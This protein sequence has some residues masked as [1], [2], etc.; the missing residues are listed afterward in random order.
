MCSKLAMLLG[1]G[2]SS[3]T[4]TN[5]PVRIPTAAAPK[6]M[7]PKRKLHIALH[8]ATDQTLYS[9]RYQPVRPSLPGCGQPASQATSYLQ[10]SEQEHVNT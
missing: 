6:K 5:S 4:D 1:E 2:T 9:A 10:P 3:Q 8:S 7:T